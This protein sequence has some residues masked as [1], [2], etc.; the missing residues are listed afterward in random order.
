MKTKAEK[1]K[2]VISGAKKIALIAVCTALIEG[3]K[4]ALSMIPNVEVV[5]LLCALFGYVFGI[6]GI[7]SVFLFAA[8]EPLIW[9]IGSWIIYYFIYWPLVAFIFMLFGKKKV[10]NR[11]ILTLTAGVL[12]VFFGVLSAVVDVLVYSQP[13]NFLRVFPG[14]YARGATF[15]IVQIVCN[16]ILFP[17]CFIPLADVL[18]KLNKK[19]CLSAKRP[20]DV[21]V[22]VGTDET[23]TSENDNPNENENKSETNENQ[24]PSGTNENQNPSESVEDDILGENQ[25]LNNQIETNENQNSDNPIENN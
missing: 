21:E 1:N 25:D 2:L 14:Y 23:R 19:F 16:L 12:T 3:C 7:I 18:T 11:L 9:G 4:L 20:K 24:N 13:S 8:I 5:T 15:Y 22:T 6:Y 17:L 10:R